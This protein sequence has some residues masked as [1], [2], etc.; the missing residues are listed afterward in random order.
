MLLLLRGPRA[1]PGG[2]PQ[3]GNLWY[4]VLNMPETMDEVQYTIIL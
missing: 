2:A 4:R 3:F 1:P